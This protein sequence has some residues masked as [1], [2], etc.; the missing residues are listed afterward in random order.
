MVAKAIFSLCFALLFVPV[1]ALCIWLPIMFM[2]IGSAI[3][4]TMG[5]WLILLAGEIASLALYF[6]WPWIA[7]FVSWVD[8]AMILSGLIPWKEHSAHSFVHQFGFDL[9]FFG[10]ANIGFIASRFR[11]SPQQV[12]D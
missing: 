8:M 4:W 9:M 2:A 3:P 10:L 6:K 12:H 5:F 11:E 7:V 1:L